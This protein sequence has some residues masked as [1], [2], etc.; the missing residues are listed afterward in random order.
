[1]SKKKESKPIKYLHLNADAFMT[2]A[3][4]DNFDDSY[5]RRGTY[6]EWF[7]R[8]I[9]LSDEDGH[10]ALPADFDVAVG[11]TVYVVAAVYSTGDTFGHDHGQML[12]VISV[13]KNVEIARKNKKNLESAVRSGRGRFH[14]DSF[15]EIHFDNGKSLKRTVPWDGYFESLD[16][17]TV[18]ELSVE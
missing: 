14:D 16:Y 15:V 8:G 17:V 13:H 1:M 10:M 18:E 11:D 9:S 5:G 2:L 6:T 7:L 4:E 3:E 12:E